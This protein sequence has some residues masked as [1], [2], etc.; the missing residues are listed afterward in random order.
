MSR[1]CFVLASDSIG[2]RRAELLARREALDDLRFVHHDRARGVLDRVDDK[3]K[4]KKTFGALQRL[5]FAALDRPAP[6]LAAAAAMHVPPD[7]I[8]RL[9]ARGRRPNT[10]GTG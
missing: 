7:R 1:T 6:S 3:A 2:S 10:V 5:V 8:A 9:A 4:L